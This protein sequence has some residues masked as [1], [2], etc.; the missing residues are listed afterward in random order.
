MFTAKPLK[1]LI[2]SF[3]RLPGIGPKTAA[4]LTFYLLHVPQEELDKFAS[5]LS[6]LKKEIIS[7]KDFEKQVQKI[8]D[9]FQKRLLEISKKFTL[10]NTY[11]VGSFSEFKEIIEKRGGFIRASWC[12]SNKCEKQIQEE[13][14]ATI[15]C[16]LNEKNKSGKCIRCGKKAK[17]EVLFAKAY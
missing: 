6:N 8:L 9:G 17:F 11:R 7:L 3:E 14:K 13:T 5:A 12:G 1:R 4:R 15:R 10:D 16:M 2:E